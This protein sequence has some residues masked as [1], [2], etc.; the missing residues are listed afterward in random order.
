MVNGDN[1]PEGTGTPRVEVFF[2]DLVGITGPAVVSS[3][4]RGIGTIT[5]D[6]AV[7]TVTAISD[8]TVTE[9]NDGQVDANFEVTLSGNALAA[10]N[11]GFATA[12]GSASAGSDYVAQS[13]TLT[14]PVGQSKGTI[15]I[16]V[17]GD[18]A[19]EG[20][21]D[22]HVDLTS[23]T[24]AQFGGD[25][26]GTAI[27][28]NDDAPRSLAITGA[29]VTEGTGSGNFA[30]LDFKVRLS[31]STSQQVQVTATTSDGTATAPADYQ[32]KTQV[33]TWAPNSAGDQLEKTFTVVVNPDS[34]DEAG[35]TLIV[36][37]SAPANAVISG[38]SATGTIN[39]N[40][41]NSLLA[42]SNAE[43]NEGTGGT[44]S[45]MTFKVTLSPASART[46]SAN[47]GTANGTASAGS[48]YEAKQGSVTFGP[49]ETE[50]TIELVIL[51][52]DVNEEN[53]TVLV[54]L[55]DV[56]GAGLAGG[57]G[58]GSGTIV[59][60]NA[61]PSLSINDVQA[62]E[63]AGATFTVTLAGTTLRTVS[64]AF[65]TNGG[66]AREGD[67]FLP[68]SGTLT[69]APGE[70]TKTVAV[71]VFDD[72]LPEP[73]ETFA[74]GLGNPVNATITKGSGI[75]TIEASDLAD[76]AGPPPV[77]PT[78]PPGVIKPPPD[79]GP[80]VFPQ[81]VLG[82]RIVVMRKGLAK[83]TVTCNK[84]SKLVCA[85]TILLQTTTKPAIKLGQKTFSVKKGKKATVTI[86]VAKDVRALIAE[87]RTIK[88]K[89]I[90]LV[91]TNKKK[92]VRIEPGTITV[93]MPTAQTA[94]SRP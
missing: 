25:R 65:G 74:V 79:A 18:A 29:T 37:L 54:N 44:T 60:R 40:D 41:N 93:R 43:A 56:A 92:P 34:L 59:D 55:A 58:Q 2:V 27:I 66:S 42:V 53:E 62:A 38:A 21:E 64:V 31:G 72:P 14:I 5:D 51:G 35:E 73:P 36:S 90:V 48:D 28:E 61:P 63:G 30:N 84:A 50:K 7:P 78:L 24:L 16:K 52:D 49:G 12:D 47:F 89:V 75:G 57:G 22:F 8:P 94:A 71:T 3:D 46:V 80:Q 85:G 11:I 15:T 86:A 17:N 67:D 76:V 23:V 6:D 32:V 69:F 82:P 45:K 9:G 70:K 68:R 77:Q 20:N 26:R 88:V 10:V 1:I 33:I 13:G 19:A 81:M 91:K 83:M 87:L 39:D 4:F